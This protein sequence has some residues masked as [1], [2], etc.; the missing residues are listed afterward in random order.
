MTEFAPWQYRARVAEVVDGDT[1]D[2]VFD[3]GFDIEMERRVRLLGIDTAEIHFVS[4]DSEEYERGM[5]QKEF[6][7]EWVRSDEEWPL[8]AKTER[9]QKGKYGRYLADLY[10]PDEKTFLSD[11][12][13][14]EFGDEVVYE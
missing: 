11:A 7:E 1:F 10:D 9:D 12:L 14:D 6:V 2:V 13:V 4:H 8:L 3:L 5:A